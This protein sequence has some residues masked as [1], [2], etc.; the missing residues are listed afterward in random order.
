MR[1]QDTPFPVKLMVLL[2]LLVP[3][4]SGWPITQLAGRDSPARY[5]LMLSV[6]GV[7]VSLFIIANSGFRDWFGSFAYSCMLA[8]ITCITGATIQF[9]SNQLWHDKSAAASQGERYLVLGATILSVVPFALFAVRCFSAA[10]LMQFAVRH[11]GRRRTLAQHMTV[12]L[13]VFQHA[14]EVLPVLFH[15]WQEEHPI[16]FAPRWNA[17]I[18]GHPFTRFAKWFIWAQEAVF[19]WCLAMLMFTLEPIPAFCAEVERLTP[20]NPDP[21]ETSQEVAT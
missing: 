15:A 21:N 16:R 9:V 18:N 10:G 20:Q 4:L 7:A 12:A 2:L 13:R 17:D 11:V 6:Y 8:T 3:A 14:T 1:I 19:K 5:A